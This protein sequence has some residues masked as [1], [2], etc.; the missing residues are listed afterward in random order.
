MKNERTDDTPDWLLDRI[1]IDRPLRRWQE[2]YPYLKSYPLERQ[3]RTIQKLSAQE[4]FNEKTWGIIKH[5][6]KE[7]QHDD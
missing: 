3:V 7:G 4:L 1:V 6:C 2:Q 5:L